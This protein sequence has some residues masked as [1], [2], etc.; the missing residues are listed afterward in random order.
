M[1]I[2]IAPTGGAMPIIVPNPQLGNPLAQVPTISD[3]KKL[4]AIASFINIA[5]KESISSD[6]KNQAMAD[7]FR[8]YMGIPEATRNRIQTSLTNNELTNI[9]QTV[10]T[11]ALLEENRKTL[12]SNTS[13]DSSLKTILVNDVVLIKNASFRYLVDVISGESI[14]DSSVKKRAVEGGVC[15]FLFAKLNKKITVKSSED[16]INFVFPRNDWLAGFYL[17][18]SEVRDLKVKYVEK[19]SMFTECSAVMVS[20]LRNDAL[21]KA[22]NFLSE[23]FSFTRESDILNRMN[24]KAVVMVPPYDLR[25]V[26]ELISAKKTGVYEG[27]WANLPNSLDPVS[28][29]SALTH[30]FLRMRLLQTSMDLSFLL[31]DLFNKGDS[32]KSALRERP[33]GEEFSVGSWILNNICEDSTCDTSLFE[34][35]FTSLSSESSILYLERYLVSQLGFLEDHRFTKVLRNTLHVHRSDSGH[36]ELLSQDYERQVT[37]KDDEGNDVITTVKSSRF[38]YPADV[39]IL[40]DAEVER[41]IT[42]HRDYCTEIKLGQADTKVPDTSSDA[43]RFRKRHFSDALADKAKAPERRGEPGGTTALTNE[44]KK[45]LRDIFI[46]N[47]G[48]AIA[49]NDYLRGFSNEGVQEYVVKVLHARENQLLGIDPMTDLHFI[50]TDENDGNVVDDIFSGLED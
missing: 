17:S 16:L 27:R 9:A 23:D 15:E 37:R 36:L 18:F 35:L 3:L 24:R 49:L 45:F 40:S 39:S 8:V 22:V 42:I 28:G 50:S 13:S 4:N 32:F 44:S 26:A 21:V 19:Y 2:D 47:K 1:R 41:P 20:L 5:K 38:Y 34:G 48:V 30:A 33:I 43:G 46:K 31:G 6:T 11:I 7:A 10:N 14:K 29:T 12:L 25:K